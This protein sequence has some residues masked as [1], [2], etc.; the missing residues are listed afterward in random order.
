MNRL[1]NAPRCLSRSLAVSLP[2]L[3]QTWLFS[4]ALPTNVTE[5][6]PAEDSLSNISFKL[7]PTGASA[8]NASSRYAFRITDYAGEAVTH[9]QLE[10]DAD[11]RV[12]VPVQLPAGYY[13]IS[14]EGAG[15][16]GQEATGLWV[17]PDVRE[18]LPSD[19]FFSIDTAISW[20]TQ[21]D[22]RQ[23]MIDNLPQVI[24]TG[25][26]ARERLAW[27][28]IHPSEDQWDWETESRYES[29][30]QAYK[31][32]GI[33]VL[34]VFHR[35]PERWGANQGGRFPVDLLSASHSWAEV[36]KRL[37]KYW[38]ALEVWNEPDISFGGNQPADQYLPMLKMVRYVMH[39][40]GIDTPIGGGVLATSNRNYITQAAL[41][42]LL[43]ECDFFSF[44]YYGD[45]MGVERLIARHRLWLDE[46]GSPNKPLWLTEIGMTRSGTTG[47]RPE[48]DV[49]AINAMTLAM[50]S[51][52]ARACGIVRLFPF[53]YP[54]Y[55]E[56]SGSRHYGMLDA[57]GT[58]LRILAAV[59]Q[60]ANALSGTEYLGD[61]PIQSQSDL[62]R[63]RVFSHP[64]KESS[65][66][67]VAYTGEINENKTINLPYTALNIQGAD[68]RNLQI[69]S[70]GE[71]P[72]P[73]GIAYLELAMQDIGADLI[74]DTEAMR[75][76]NLAQV[77]SPAP[78]APSPIVLQPQID[79]A[80]LSAIS[81]LGYFLPR[82][83]KHIAVNVNVL[84]LGKDERNI[85]IQGGLSD[86]T[87]TVPANAQATVQVEADVQSLPR[88]FAETKLL[89]ITGTSDG[90]ER[91]APVVL[92]FNLSAGLGIGEHLQESNYQYNLSLEEEYRWRKN[93]SGDMSFESDTPGAWGF[94]VTFPDGV[95]RW[96][97]PTFTLPQEVDMS[98]VTGVLLRARALGKGT[99]RIKSW[100]AQGQTGHSP[101]SIFPSD[102]E[103]HVVY[104]SFDSYLQADEGKPVRLSIGMNSSTA[105]NA[106]EVSD[107]YLIGK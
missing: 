29:T 106:I 69:G 44:H 36:A 57:R 41:N 88:G 60:T 82:D 67:V 46:F 104:V 23:S 92:A 73:D 83:K 35:T 48:A 58:P 24:G 17:R 98:Q 15:D 99:I 34:E 89:T 72:I 76:Y 85:R 6:Y 7:E 87:V 37:H 62:K 94:K 79:V 5:L 86:R 93:S 97:Y 75:L 84:N 20:L 14:F 19:P 3:L 59:A 13:E 65:V 50:Q 100:D 26:M 102:G 53:V 77:E 64:D 70:N 66:I 45:P 68:G 18:G 81:T 51:I 38:A 103:W 11:G 25:G 40:A 95:D 96:A 2:L 47:V 105:N 8:N 52:E 43:D 63:L 21:F 31:D 32:A 49:Q 61:L 9:G 22:D 78:P 42:G 1:L 74:R 107:L 28:S 90:G 56:R 71:I 30:R 16:P 80:D 101:F 54:E 12:Q 27:Q 55:S 39:D 4:S 91:V 33:E 10:A